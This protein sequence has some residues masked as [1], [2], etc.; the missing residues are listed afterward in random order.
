MY[1]VALS[2]IRKVLCDPSAAIRRRALSRP[3]SRSQLMTAWQCDIPAERLPA[4]LAAV[5]GDLPRSCDSDLLTQLRHGGQGTL[6]AGV[7]LVLASG[8]GYGGAISA[9]SGPLALVRSAA[10]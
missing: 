2:N 6:A 8:G 7:L 9:R 5:S 1:F 4:E 3:F 10:L